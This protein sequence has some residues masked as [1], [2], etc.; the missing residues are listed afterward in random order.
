MVLSVQLHPVSGNFPL[1]VAP[2]ELVLAGLECSLV[3]DLLVYT[4]R[5]I[6][7]FFIKAFQT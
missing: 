3:F 2:L 1:A 5:Q 7:L 4:A 6:G